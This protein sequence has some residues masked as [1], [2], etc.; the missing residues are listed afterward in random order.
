MAGDHRV[1]CADPAV[2]AALLGWLGG[3][4]LAWPGQVSLAVELVDTLPESGDAREDFTQ[5][6]LRIQSGPP[7]DTV[8]VRWTGGPAEALVHPTAASARL[9]LTPGALD[10]F[11]RAER[12]FL[13]VVLLFVLR[14]LGWY[15]VHCAAL[16]DP[17]GQGWMFV[18]QSNSGKSTTSALL[19]R[20]GWSVATDDIGF[21][22]DSHGAVAVAGYRSP[23]AL[24]AGGRDLLQASDGMEFARRGKTGYDADALG[25][26]WVST[27]VPDVIVFP[28]VDAHAKTALV[29][30]TPREAVRALIASSVWV[31][32]EAT[33]AQEHLDRLGQ[34]CAQCRVYSATLGPDLIARPSLLQ[35][36]LS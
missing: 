25:G 17:T 18:G 27:V 1:Q 36:M 30:V 16:R 13:L 26:S 3:A 12:G 20:S 5:P 29:R 15:H 34:L 23:I 7:D 24:R 4:G 31:L 22:T 33:H 14:R 8:R 10:D 19:A 2:R 21:L 9:W 11:E 28:T 6:E 32:A 35:E